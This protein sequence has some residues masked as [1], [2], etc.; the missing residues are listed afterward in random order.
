[1]YLCRDLTS[2]SLPAIGEAFGKNPATILHACRLIAE[3]EKADPA[4]RQ[5]LSSLREGLSR[6]VR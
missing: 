1:M 6:P 5:S 4:I 3:K 2:H